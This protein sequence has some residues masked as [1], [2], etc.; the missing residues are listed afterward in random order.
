[1]NQAQ[2]QSI[3]SASNPGFAALP[4][5]LQE[6]IKQ[7]GLQVEAEQQLQACAQHFLEK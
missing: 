1:M 6:T 3:T 4:V 2:D 5:F 7:I